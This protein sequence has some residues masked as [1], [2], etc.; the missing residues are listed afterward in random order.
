MAKMLRSWFALVLPS[1]QMRSFA[2]VA[3]LSLLLLAGFGDKTHATL[4]VSLANANGNFDSTQAGYPPP[5]GTVQVTRTSNTTANIVLTPD[6]G[7]HGS[8]GF[9]YLFGDGGTIALNVNG[10]NLSFSSVSTTSPF[11]PGSFSVQDGGAGN[12][13]SFGSFNFS[14]NATNGQGGQGGAST[15]LSKLSFTLTSAGANWLTDSDVLTPDNKGFVASA[16]LFAYTGSP[17]VTNNSAFTAYVGDADAP[18][19]PEPAT[20]VTLMSGLPFGLLALRR[21]LRQSRGKSA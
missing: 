6:A 9:F 7:P 17:S 18:A 3:A 20:V 8:G 14:L 1:R 15:A 21:R 12:Q 16:H 11:P 4:I 5:Y 2:R 13:S 19:V 10:S